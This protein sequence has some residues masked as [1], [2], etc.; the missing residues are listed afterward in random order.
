MGLYIRLHLDESATFKAAK[1]EQA[2]QKAPVK[3]I[4]SDHR[5]VTFLGMGSKVVEAAVFPFYTVFLVA[6]SNYLGQK[7]AIV[8][9]RWSPPHCSSRAAD[10]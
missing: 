5:R 7:S 8:L 10:R 3:V 4:L 1:A 9:E 6:Y 2:H